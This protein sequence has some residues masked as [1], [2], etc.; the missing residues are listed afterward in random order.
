MFF[1]PRELL[2]NEFVGKEKRQMDRKFLVTINTNCHFQLIS[3]VKIKKNVAVDK[4]SSF[5]SCTRFGAQNA[6]KGISELPDFKIFWGSMPPYPPRLRDLVAPWLYSRLFFPNQ[7]PTSNF[8][9]TPLRHEDRCK[10]SL[11]TILEKRPEKPFRLWMG[12]KPMTFALPVQCSS[13]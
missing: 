11:I 6:G 4:K 7:L 13:N 9:E 5:I 12:F 10:C 3:V 1:F 8:I 2:I